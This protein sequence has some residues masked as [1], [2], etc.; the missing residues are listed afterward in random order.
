MRVVVVASIRNAKDMEEPNQQ[1][2]ETSSQALALGRAENKQ[3]WS[4]S[5]ALATL[6]AT[7]QKKTMSS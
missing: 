1:E 5:Q 4:R 7:K 2:Q 3:D 6:V